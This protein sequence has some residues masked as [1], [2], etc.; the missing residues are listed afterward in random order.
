MNWPL[1]FLQAATA[2]VMIISLFGL[3][4]PIYPGLTVIWAASLVYGILVGFK[5]LGW[6]AWLI[7]IV[8]TLLMLFGNVIDN[9]VTGKK[10]YDSGASIWSVIVAMIAGVVGAIIWTPIGGLLVAPL[11]LLLAEYYRQREWRKALEST[12][13]WL[14]GLGWAFI[15]RFL[16]GMAMIGL[17][18]IWALNTH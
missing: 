3:L 17:W 1:I 10:A 13:G 8:I 15:L 11:A 18:L 4:I 16:T 12:R 2:T 14:V 9:I 5:A 6:V 7:F